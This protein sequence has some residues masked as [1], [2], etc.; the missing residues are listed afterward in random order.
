MSNNVLAS[1]LIAVLLVLPAGGVAAQNDAPKPAGI[2]VEQGSPA[3]QPPSK[4]DASPIK[5][6]SAAGKGR[7]EHMRD[8]ARHCL[9]LDTIAEIIKC[10]E[11]YRY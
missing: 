8:D 4:P 9:E 1:G 3:S 11:P 7:V 6:A 10:A 2:K 5:T